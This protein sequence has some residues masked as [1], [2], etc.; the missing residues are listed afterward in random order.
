MKWYPFWKFF[1]FTRQQR[2]AIFL[3]VSLILL[4]QLVKKPLF[5]F[6]K[7]D[8][9]KKY[10]VESQQ[11]WIELKA[12]IDS[13]KVLQQK[14][15][16]KN[17]TIVSTTKT[18]KNK[19][20][21]NS[22]AKNTVLIIDINSSDAETF[23]KLKGI[24]SVF[25]NRII[26]YRSKLGGFYSVNQISEVYGISDSL[27]TTIEKQ[28]TIKTKG[29]KKLK[30]NQDEFE[31]LSQHPYISKTLAKQI[32][33]YRTKVKTFDSIEEIKKMY[34]MTDSI[35]NKLYPYLTID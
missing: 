32:V 28:L 8:T 9:S 34:A 21:P 16:V 25:S 27:F 20:N 5:D 1:Y 6:L 15:N 7:K 31:T 2:A 33:G 18:Y 30:I 22:P 14:K 23:Q 19:T 29:L 11:K 13:A 4:V 17:T 26:S 35:Y 10:I 3:M 24:G 12:Q